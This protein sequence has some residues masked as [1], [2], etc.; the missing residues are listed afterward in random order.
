Y[1]H[2]HFQKIYIYARFQEIMVASV[3]TLLLIP[4][5]QCLLDVSWWSSVAQI[6]IGSMLVGSG[7]SMSR[8]CPQLEGLSPG[9]AR[10]C[11]LFHEHMPAVGAGAYNAI[12]ECQHQFRDGRWNC[13]TPTSSTHLGPIHKK[14]T[15]EAA[16]T[17]AIL[18]AGVAHEIGRRCKQ[19]GLP[20]CGCSEEGRPGSIKEDWAWTGCGDN[21][22][23]G[24]RFSKDFIDVREKEYDGKRSSEDGKS[25]V[26]RRNNEAGRK[27]LKKNSSPKCKCH[28][29]S[30]ACNLKTCWLQ[31][32]TMRRM[33]DVL[34]KK[35]YNAH[36]VI[37][38]TRGNM[39][40]IS[41]ENSGNGKRGRRA[42]LTD[43]V[44]LDDSPDYCRHDRSLG[45][46]GTNGRQC[47]KDS[48]GGDGCDILC[49]GRGYNQQTIQTKSKCRCKFE[50]CCQVVCDTCLNTTSIHTCK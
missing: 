48:S 39:Q 35:Y 33:G 38:N 4:V 15:K 49:C 22:D 27:L 7:G 3:I 21:V 30:G 47:R 45:T 37:I 43:L 34:S 41:G 5:A 42:L 11:Q 28:G 25:L 31:L 50:W 8:L 36:R 40:F 19:G 23:Y 18:S 17:Y 2:L 13:S 14:A 24:Y 32:P 44:F 12:Q 1:I 6:N 20:S 9:Q 10:I 26:N 16:F 46:V 29:V